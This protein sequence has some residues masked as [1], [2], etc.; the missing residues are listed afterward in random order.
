MGGDHPH[1]ETLAYHAWKRAAVKTIVA[2]AGYDSAENH[3]L[4]RCD[5]SCRSFIPPLIGRQSDKEL[6]DPWR[7]LMKRVWNQPSVQKIYRQRWQ[8]ETVNSMMKRNYGSALR[9]RTPE[10]REKEMLLKAMTHNI[11][12]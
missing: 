3:H 4:V 2:D 5:L 6:S 11:A 8:V 9:A 10:R 1:F 7:A 12:I